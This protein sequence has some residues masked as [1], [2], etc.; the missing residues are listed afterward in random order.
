MKLHSNG[1]TY[2]L[3]NNLFSLF[4]FFLL[5]F[6]HFFYLPFLFSLFLPSFSVQPPLFFS[7][8]WT[9][10]LLCPSP[11]SCWAASTAADRLLV[12][13]Y[14]AAISLLLPPSPTPDAP[15]SG[16]PRWG[17]SATPAA[18]APS[19]CP[20]QVLLPCGRHH[21]IGSDARCCLFWH[22]S[23]GLMLFVK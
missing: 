2:G 20:N 18:A 4:L 1:Y 14:V 15:R 19:L 12:A 3:I 22:L 11:S 10:D 21:G 17:A 5:I 23:E 16:D 7:P 9:Y 8:H 6:S 13:S